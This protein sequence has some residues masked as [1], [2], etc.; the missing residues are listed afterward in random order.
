[1]LLAFAHFSC[2]LSWH[3]PHF[4][5]I[6][7]HRVA[8]EI[9]CV[10]EG[11]SSSSSR[12]LDFQYPQGITCDLMGITFPPCFAIAVGLR[13]VS[14]FVS[15]EAKESIYKLKTVTS[16]TLLPLSW[17]AVLSSVGGPML[18][19]INEKELVNSYSASRNNWCTV[20]GDGGCR[21]SEVRAGTTFPMPDHK[22]FKL[23]WLVNFQKFSTL[24]VNVEAFYFSQKG[25]I[26]SFVFD[27]A[28][29]TLDIAGGRD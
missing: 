13:L 7:L 22:G 3:W 20:G 15:S 18:V 29:T 16:Y 24:R 21:V 12:L 10:W 5:T 1:M 25:Q 2:S 14:S 19:W 17:P 9:C 6:I 11:A 23:Q 27:P 4:V 28:M 8:I 26:F